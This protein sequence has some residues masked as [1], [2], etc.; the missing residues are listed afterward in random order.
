MPSSFNLRPPPPTPSC[1]PSLPAEV[2]RLHQPRSG[3]HPPP[4][5]RTTSKLAIP[6]RVSTEMRGMG[7]GGT[8]LEASNQRNVNNIQVRPERNIRYSLQNLAKPRMAA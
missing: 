1:P 8:P 7:I 3:H 6:N 4:R 2:E 5:R